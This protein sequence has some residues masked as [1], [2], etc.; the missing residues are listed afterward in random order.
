MRVEQS[1]WLVP[2]A[3]GGEGRGGFEEEFGELGR[4]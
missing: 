3:K 1:S 2:A 4:D